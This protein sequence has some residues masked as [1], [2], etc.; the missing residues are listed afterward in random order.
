MH[1]LINDVATIINYTYACRTHSPHKWMK[2][3]QEESGGK[4]TA[5]AAAGPHG[6]VYSVHHRN[7]I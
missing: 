2:C 7:F 3:S 6:G 5:G 4:T 1:S